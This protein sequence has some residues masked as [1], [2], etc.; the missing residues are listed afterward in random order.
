MHL[1][2]LLKLP[3]VS[4]SFFWN[5]RRV[6]RSKTWYTSPS[7]ESDMWC[8]LRRSFNGFVFLI[9]FFSLQICTTIRKCRWNQM[10]STIIIVRSSQ[11][12]AH[13]L[14]IISLAFHFVVVAA[15]TAPSIWFCH[16]IFY[17][18]VYFHYFFFFFKIGNNLK[19]VFRLVSSHSLT[20]KRLLISSDELFWCALT[21][22]KLHGRFF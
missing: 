10:F 1:S 17:G 6:M 9:I 2:Q 3:H 18:G 12:F 19:I 5:K 21:S 7:V 8:D 15:V 16:V 4:Y 20:S 13:L 14:K 11:L 22:I